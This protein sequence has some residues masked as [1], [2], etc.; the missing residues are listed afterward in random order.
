[1][2]GRRY[3]GELAAPG[4]PAV[5]NNVALEAALWCSEGGGGQ[6]LRKAQTLGTRVLGTRRAPL[7]WEEGAYQGERLLPLGRPAVNSIWRPKQR[8]G[9]LR[10]GRWGLRRLSRCPWEEGAVTV[11]L[12]TFGGAKTAVPLLS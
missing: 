1:L 3:Q 9:A 10:G 8:C 6:K 11:R 4:M 5:N 7:C 12:S 2:G